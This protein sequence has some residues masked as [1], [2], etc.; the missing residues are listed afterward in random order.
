LAPSPSFP[1]WAAMAPSFDSRV[2]LTLPMIALASILCNKEINTGC[3]T[4]KLLYLLS[5]AGLRWVCRQIRHNRSF[6]GVLSTCAA[7]QPARKQLCGNTRAVRCLY[8]GCTHVSTIA[9]GPAASLAHQRTCTQTGIPERST[10]SVCCP[11][12]NNNMFL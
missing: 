3:L 1:A 7:S 12:E 5:S 8:C 2:D 6:R 9:A 10:F 11:E 4:H